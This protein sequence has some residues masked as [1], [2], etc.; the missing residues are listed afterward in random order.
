MIELQSV[1]PHI[2]TFVNVFSFCTKKKE[3]LGNLATITNVHRCIMYTALDKVL[4]MKVQILPSKREV[5]LKLIL[6]AYF[7]SLSCGKIASICHKQLPGK[8]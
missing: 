3:F 5:E 7:Q 1:V 8:T 6:G 4:M 2:S